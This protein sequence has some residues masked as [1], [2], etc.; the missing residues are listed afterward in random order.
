MH[1]KVGT[2]SVGMCS[3]LGATPELMPKQKT[4]GQSRT[5]TSGTATS[6]TAQVETRA[7]MGAVL[8]W[9]R[10]INGSRCNRHGVPGHV[11]LAPASQREALL[12]EIELV[13][14]LL[15]HASVCMVKK[16][17]AQEVDW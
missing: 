8:P 13:A 11:A 10:G 14:S 17:H 6:G 1:A 15:R 4:W 16:V 3:P 7:G 12:Y 5:A 2:S 9:A